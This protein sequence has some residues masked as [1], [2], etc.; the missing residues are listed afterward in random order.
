MVIYYTLSRSPIMTYN[1]DDNLICLCRSIG[2]MYL[3]KIASVVITEKSTIGLG[4]MKRL[5]FKAQP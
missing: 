4:N 1:F 2:G 3:R 5:D